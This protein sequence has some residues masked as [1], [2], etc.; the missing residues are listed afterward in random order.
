MFP[1]STSTVTRL[2][3]GAISLKF[4]P[5]AAYRRLGDNQ[6]G[7]ISAGASETSYDA[8]SDRVTRDHEHN[9]NCLRLPLQFLHNWCYYR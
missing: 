1:D 9:G 8:R 2:T 3:S 4:Q 5:F 6:A 7:G